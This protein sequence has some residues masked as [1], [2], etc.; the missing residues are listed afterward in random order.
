MKENS[1][2]VSQTSVECGVHRKNIKRWMAQEG[3][4][5]K[6][7]QNRHVNSRERR[8]VTCELILACTKF[9]GLAIF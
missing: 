7:I 1:G 4:I 6:S 9:S 2:N 8:K 5:K 3:L